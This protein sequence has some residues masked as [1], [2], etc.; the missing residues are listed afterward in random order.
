MD[1]WK[2]NHRALDD[3]RK[4][5]KVEGKKKRRRSSHPDDWTPSNR[6][7]D[8]GGPLKKKS[9]SEGVPKVRRVKRTD[10][11]EPE[12]KVKS[13]IKQVANKVVTKS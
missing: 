2:P 5:K 4:G 10:T 3:T 7:L 9:K 12:V 13:K 8:V 1:E 11:D 6:I